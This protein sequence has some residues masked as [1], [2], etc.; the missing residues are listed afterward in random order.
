M[1]ADQLQFLKKTKYNLKFL[2]VLLC[3]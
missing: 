1:S 2:V 3:E